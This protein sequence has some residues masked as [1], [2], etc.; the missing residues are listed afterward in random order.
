MPGCNA[1]LA[2]PPGSSEWLPGR[3]G[4]PIPGSIM[5]GGIAL[6]C[7]AGLLIAACAEEE[8][9]PSSPEPSQPAVN[10]SPYASDR[11]PDLTLRVN[12]QFGFNGY[13]YFTDPD[14]DPLSFSGSSNNR[15]IA[16]VFTSRE[17]VNVETHRAG[18]A[19][20]TVTARDPRGRSAS[21]SFRVTVVR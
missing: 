7:L 10:R 2:H 1:A 13:G 6:L 9:A 14:D 4:P 12:V 16:S 18:S 8:S 20:V 19:T 3:H 11:I 5:F 21:Q 15:N 17:S